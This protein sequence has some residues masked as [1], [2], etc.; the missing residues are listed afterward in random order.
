[1]VNQDCQ[2]NK[3]I[4]ESN[5]ESIGGIVVS[6]VKIKV[7]SRAR[8]SL[9]IGLEPFPTFLFKLNSTELNALKE[10]EF[11]NDVRKG[12]QIESKIWKEVYEKKILKFQNLSF[13][14]KHFNYHSIDIYGIS[15]LG[16]N[17]LPVD[18]LNELR[19]NFHTRGNYY[20]A[21]ALALFGFGAGIWMLIV[22]R[23]PGD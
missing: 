19:A 16:K 11:I 20:G 15:Q 7:S 12:N 2:G 5:T 22:S 3:R 10:E 23:M 14:Y 21:M 17:Y 6:D 1:M 9:E 13:K 4:E 18:E 8:R